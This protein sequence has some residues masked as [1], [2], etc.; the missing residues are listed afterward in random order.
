MLIFCSDLT[1]RN[2][3][4]WTW[5]DAS[6]TVK[7]NGELCSGGLAFIQFSEDLECHLCKS[8]FQCGALRGHS[9][10]TQRIQEGSKAAT[11][12]SRNCVAISDDEDDESEDEVENG[13]DD[14]DCNY[15]DQ[16][17]IGK[18]PPRPTILNA[19]GIRFLLKTRRILCF[20]AVRPI[21]NF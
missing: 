15:A 6:N 8:G 19:G 5:E 4:Q 12:F 7:I 13:T 17:D 2:A 14:G 9:K 10:Q 11:G 16:G 3:L 21:A 1:T 20:K 18:A